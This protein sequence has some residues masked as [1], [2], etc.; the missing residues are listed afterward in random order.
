LLQPGERLPA[1]RELCTMM[2]ISR[3]TL[4]QALVALVQSG[5]LRAVRGRGGGT[6]VADP[7]PPA[8]RPRPELVEGWRDACDMRMA[9]ELGVA[10]LA[11]AR[12]TPE[13]VDRLDALVA[14]MSGRLEDFSAYRQ[15]DY[16]LHIGLAELTGSAR[17]VVAETEAQSTIDDLISYIAHPPEVLAWGNA[18]HARL[19]AAVRA[20]DSQ[21]AVAIMAEHV[22]GTEHVIAGLLPRPAP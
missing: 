6:F 2:G 18:Q 4:R 9:V 1:E 5:H 16:R 15:A 13:A 8:R 14:A 11:A 20:G 7:Q 21:G 17:L 3:S 12:A 10:H 19:L 22:E